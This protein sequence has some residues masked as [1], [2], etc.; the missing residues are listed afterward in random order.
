MYALFS[1]GAALAC[2]FVRLDDRACVSRWYS[3]ILRASLH[4]L[5]GVLGVFQGFQMH[6][7]QCTKLVMQMMTSKFLVTK[8]VADV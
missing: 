8:L 3:C 6:M 1:V 4:A 5:E 2:S 7:L